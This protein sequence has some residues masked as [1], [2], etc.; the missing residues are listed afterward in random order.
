MGQN[1]PSAKEL[2]QA[3]QYLRGRLAL[4]MEDGL[5]AAIFHSRQWLLE[6]QIR[7]F[8]DIAAGID[9]VDLAQAAAVAKELF[10]PSGL[11]VAVIG[12]RVDE[13][14]LQQLLASA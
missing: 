10:V 5:S 4:S 9:K 11:N 14:K 2:T 1:G 8:E 12:P 7:T 6:G 13:A 3:K